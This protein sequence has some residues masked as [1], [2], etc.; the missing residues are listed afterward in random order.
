VKFTDIV[1]KEEVED[2]SDSVDDLPLD[3][4]FEI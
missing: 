4:D 3:D 1:K 2:V